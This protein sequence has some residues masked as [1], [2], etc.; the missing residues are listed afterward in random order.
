MDDSFELDPWPTIKIVGHGTTAQV[1]INGVKVPRLLAY[2]VEQN[3]HEKR[4]AEVT[5]RV[6]CNLDLEVTTIPNL[7]EPWLT[8]IK[9]ADGKIDPERLKVVCPE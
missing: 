9:G 6:Q 7:P 4:M 1:Y 3:A 5:L 2:K 8:L